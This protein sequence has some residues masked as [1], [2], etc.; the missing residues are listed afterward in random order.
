MR[1]TIRFARFGILVLLPF[2]GCATGSVMYLPGTLERPPAKQAP[3]PKGS[4]VY[5]LDFRY[6]G[7][8]EVGRDYELAR[9]I[10][11]EASPGKAVADLV[12]EA[13][14]ERG[15]HAVRV[16][17]RA[18]IPAEGAPTVEGEV[19]AFRVE[20]RKS[21]ALRQKA[22][23]TATVTITLR[24]TGGTSPPGWSSTLSSEFVQT[25]PL[26]IT[27]EGALDAANRSANAVADEAVRRLA[28]AG[29]VSLP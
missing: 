26:F 17:D 27:P 5:V 12:A 6:R 15:I 19:N 10:V 24:G 20:A 29:V 3:E 14:R 16:A 22:D 13:L 1:D 23:L 28:A 4:P 21:G 8:G 25:D 18:A 9:P 11:W 2:L 7:T